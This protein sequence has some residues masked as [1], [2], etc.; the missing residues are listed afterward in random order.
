MSIKLDDFNTLEV[1]E[2]NCNLKLAMAGVGLAGILALDPLSAAMKPGEYLNGQWST[3]PDGSR[4]ITFTYLK[5]DDNSGSLF[6]ATFAFG[7]DGDDEWVT[8]TIDFLENQFT[9]GGDISA[10]E[11]GTFANPPVDASVTDIGDASVTLNSCGSATLNFDFDEALTDIA[12]V[13]WDLEPLGNQV[14]RSQGAECPYE[15]EF[16]GCPS[17]AT[18]VPGFDRACLLSGKFENQDL[19]LTNDTTWVFSGLVEI[20]G[21]DSTGGSENVNP[22][23]LTIEP[24]TTIIGAGEAADFLYVNPGSKIFAE[25][26][27]AA[28]IVW[29][30]PFDG[31]QEGEFPDA[32]DV[33]G[34]VIAG[35][36]QCNA[37]AIGNRCQSEFRE[38]L[39][40]GRGDNPLNN[41]SSGVIRYFQVRYAGIE[42]VQD[43]EVNAFTFQGVGRGTVVD[44]IQA[45]RGADDGVE[46]FGGTV[47]VKYAVFAAGEDD[48]IDWDTGWAG[49]LQYGLVTYISA[50]GGDHGIEGAGNPDNFDAQP[51]T[52]PVLSNVTF[53]GDAADVENGSGIRFKEG[54]AGQVWN[55]GVTGFNNACLEFQDIPTYTAAGTPANPSGI[56]AFAGTLL[57]SGGCPTVFKDED[58]PPYPVED[59]F[60]SAEFPGNAVVSDLMLDGFQPMPGSPSLGNGVQVFD[61]G[62]GETE[63]FFDTTS[64]SGA[65]DGTND[66]TKGWTIDIF[67][68]E[69]ASI[70][71]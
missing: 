51:R 14:G 45:Y 38:D 39:L 3:V 32:G 71:Q 25:G 26:T 47:N 55:S 62:S 28:P 42:F 68:T 16:T 8:V 11:G 24:G 35:N 44:H 67:G 60:L 7:P 46:F 37:V 13:T 12:D 23:T 9:A 27:A 52:Q 57:S 61:L 34:V 4:G 15:Q 6:G 21:V 29:T 64:Y 56:T 54:T 59:F 48:G 33:G 49:K 5:D 1:Y 2:M 43:R 30:S 18:E 65:F 10:V 40:Y 69:A 66:W 22:S 31:F 19:V 17:F 53:I 63:E 36:A 20:G 41:E 50:F 58:A 70:A